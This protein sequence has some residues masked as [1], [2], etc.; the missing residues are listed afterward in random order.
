SF[1]KDQAELLSRQIDKRLKGQDKA[2][3]WAVMRAEV[4]MTSA[5]DVGLS[6]KD[7]EFIAGLK[8]SLEDVCRAYGIPLDLVGGERTYENVNAAMKAVWTN[9]IIPEAE[10]LADDITEQLLPMFPGAAD[11]AKFDWTQV[12]ELQEDRAEIVAQINSL[13]DKVPINKL[14]SEFMPQLLPEQG[15]GYEW[16]DEPLVPINMVPISQAGQLAGFGQMSAQP[17]GTRRVF[18]V[19]A[20]PSPQARAIEYDGEDHRRLW[21]RFV[22]RTERE[23]GPFAAFVRDL[24]RRQQQSVLAKLKGRS[25]DAAEVVAN[26]FNLG[27]WVKKFRVEV[28]P[29]LRALLERVGQEAIEDLLD[30]LPDPVDIDFDVDDPRMMRFLEQRAQRFAE[31]VNETTWGELQEALGEGMAEGE[32]IP[33]LAARVKKVMGDRIESSAETIARTEVIGAANG[34]TLETWRQSGVVEGKMWLAAI[35][36][37]TRDSHIRAHGQVVGINED[38]V[39]DSGMGPAPGQIG[40]GGEDINCRCTMTAVLDM[41]EWTGQPAIPMYSPVTMEG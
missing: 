25:R 14:L 15:Q 23:E 1:S 20:L 19:P 31:K 28:R 10:M 18:T 17:A 5:S 35:D 7:A 3:K 4:G 27:E 38:F 37:R 12:H 39:L 30:S 33:E 41:E 2:H 8:W 34:G 9:T 26:P 22:A 6:P 40:V 16:G 13:A 21:G 24:F 36:Q 11:V 29:L 32:G